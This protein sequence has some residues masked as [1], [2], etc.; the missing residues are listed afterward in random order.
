MKRAAANSRPLCMLWNTVMPAFLSVIPPRAF[1]FNTRGAPHEYFSAI[2]VAFLGACGNPSLHHC[3]G[4]R[5]GPPGTFQSC[6]FC[7]NHGNRILP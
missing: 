1:L 5:L 2:R 7:N 6:H 3:V 4:P